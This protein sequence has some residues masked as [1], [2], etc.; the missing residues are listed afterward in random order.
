MFFDVV[1][2]VRCVFLQVPHY[3]S[4]SEFLA[5]IAKT[6][7]KLCKGGGFDFAAAA[8]V[9]LNEWTSGKVRHFCLPPEEYDA[10]REAAA[11]GL[12]SGPRFVSHLSEPFKIA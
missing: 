8:E 2:V 4:T 9:V 1:V 10:E 6:R 11:A 5:H 3:G 12:I 7:G